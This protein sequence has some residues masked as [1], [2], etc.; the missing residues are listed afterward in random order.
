M[1]GHRFS[2]WAP[3]AEGVELVLGDGR[4]MPMQPDGRRPPD[5]PG[6]WALRVEEVAEDS[7]YGFSLGGGPT[8]PDPRSLWQ[9]D[10]P[11]GLSRLVEPARFQWSDERWT[12]AHLPAALLYELHVGTFT[13][14]GTFDSAIPRLDHLVDLGVTAVELMP[15]AEFPG[16][17]GWGYDGV[18]LFAAHHAYGGPHGL[19]RLVDACH[20]R[21]LAV[22]LD[23]VY[24]HLGPAG[25][26]LGEFGPY[27]TDRYATPWGQALNLDGPGSDEV[28]RFFIDNARSWLGQYHLDGLRL[29]AVHAIVDTSAGHLLEDLSVAVAGL[30]AH[31]GR[32]LFL[33]AES[34]LNDPRVVRP[35]PV[36]GFGIDAQWSDDF[37]HAL[38]AVL[39]GENTGYYSDFGT[40]DDVATALRQA[41]VYDGRR[42]GHRGRRHGR[43]PEGLPGGSFL[44][45]LQNHDQIGNRAVGERSS[46]LMSVGRLK[47]AAALVLCSPFVPMLFQGEEW[48]ASTPFQYFTAHPDPDLGRAVSE[49]R[50]SE[51]ES[52]GWD[53]EDIPDPQDPATF[54]RSQL[55]WSELGRPPH[56]ELLDWHRQLIALR[57]RRPELTDGRLDQVEVRHGEA[58]LSLRRGEVLVAVNIGGATRTLPLDGPGPRLLLGSEEKVSLVP[59]GVE[60]VPDSAAVVSFEA[61][62]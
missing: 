24:N 18:D 13:P 26:Y 62:S 30:S 37:H 27:F 53:P 39:T 22:V 11:D 19:A 51:F 21:G 16:E 50:R 33:I 10:G 47:V 3:S 38:H 58:W 48:G 9:P 17:R 56:A 5:R 25:N 36:G 54:E 59:G 6:W 61:V 28:R 4:R 29:D 45:Y 57:R 42:S 49:G 34:D 44:G 14:E 43:R 12:G 7:D 31:V 8:R 35:R 52:F 55:D 41:F 23:V 15:V 32:R 20:A 2:V 46:A 1:S 60:L 40:M